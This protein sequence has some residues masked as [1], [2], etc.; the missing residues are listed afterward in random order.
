MSFTKNFTLKKRTKVA[1][2]TF[3]QVSGATL[4]ILVSLSTKKNSLSDQKVEK[5]EK[6]EK[7]TWSFHKYEFPSLIQGPI[8][9]KHVLK[10]VKSSFVLNNTSSV[11][12]RNVFTVDISKAKVEMFHQ[13]GV[14]HDHVEDVASS[15]FHL[16]LHQDALTVWHHHTQLSL[17][18][19]GFPFL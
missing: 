4:E 12:F 14:S 3:F 5:I 13:V 8:L 15:G 11:I 7:G 1:V 17:R 10:C 9:C 2:G 16:A 19:Q 6:I 18:G